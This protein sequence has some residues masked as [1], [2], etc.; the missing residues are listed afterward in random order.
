MEL[1]YYLQTANLHPKQF[2][3][4]VYMFTEAHFLQ[5]SFTLQYL[6][7]WLVLSTSIDAR[8]SDQLVQAMQGAMELQHLAAADLTPS[9]LPDPDAAAKRAVKKFGLFRR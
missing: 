2:E 5:D 7:N 3:S 9:P 1:Q 6:K 4:I 8:R